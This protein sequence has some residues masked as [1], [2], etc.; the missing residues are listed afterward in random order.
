MRRAKRTCC[1]TIE[2]FFAYTFLCRMIWLQH[3]TSSRNSD[4]T[5][6]SLKVACAFTFAR[7]YL[8]S[9]VSVTG[10][11]IRQGVMAQMW[12]QTNEIRRENGSVTTIYKRCINLWMIHRLILWYFSCNE[13]LCHIFQTLRVWPY[14]L[15]WVKQT[16]ADIVCT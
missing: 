13:H 6:Q 5:T 2:I 10:H 11:E 16:L 12:D 1:S 3:F 14:E 8:M 7:I 9:G 4:I 15:K